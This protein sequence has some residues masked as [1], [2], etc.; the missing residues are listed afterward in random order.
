MNRAPF[1]GSLSART[2][3]PCARAIQRLPEPTDNGNVLLR[4]D[5][6]E[7]NYPP[8]PAVRLESIPGLVEHGLFLGENVARVFVGNPH[9]D[10]EEL[11]RG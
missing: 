10:A 6:G 3:P 4:A 11:E 9:G 7:I 2:S 5:F 8:E 1:P